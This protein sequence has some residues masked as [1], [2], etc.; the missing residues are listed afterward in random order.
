MRRTLVMLAAS[1]FAISAHAQIGWNLKQCRQHWGKELSVDT[2]YHF[3]WQGWD[4]DAEFKKG[5]DFGITSIVASRI[6]GSDPT[7]KQALAF[8]AQEPSFRWTRINNQN[9][10]WHWKGTAKYAGS[11]EAYLHWWPRGGLY[12][13]YID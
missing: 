13:L 2:D 11:H 4:V 7:E 5:D 8:L 6:D 3:Q 10:E 12:V 9:S 1:L